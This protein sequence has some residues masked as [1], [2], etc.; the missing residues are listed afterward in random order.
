MDALPCAD[1]CQ[2]SENIADWSL[3]ACVDIY[4]LP[5][6]SVSVSPHH[7]WNTD[8]LS[9][10]ACWKRGVW[11]GWEQL[12]NGSGWIAL[13][14]CLQCLVLGVWSSALNLL[15]VTLLFP[16]LV[17]THVRVSSSC[18]FMVCECFH[19]PGFIGQRRQQNCPVNCDTR[20]HSKQ[21]CC[22]MWLACLG[23]Q[24][25]SIWP[26]TFN[27]HS[28][29]NTFCKQTASRNYRLC[30]KWRKQV[31]NFSSNFSKIPIVTVW[32]GLCKG[33]IRAT[34]QMKI[35]HFPDIWKF[36]YFT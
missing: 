24:S 17:C 6:L 1:L 27:I 31:Y 16:F 33:K 32:L 34:V 19:S 4:A 9:G 14:T 21:H 13:K 28:A 10:G 2:E 8:R 23:E 35:R 18:V 7:Q 36:T 25:R 3:C 30:V 15:A 26:T 20:P 5:I 11:I 29:C 22:R 12:R